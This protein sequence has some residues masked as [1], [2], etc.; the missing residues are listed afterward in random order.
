MVTPGKLLFDFG[1]GRASSAWEIINDGVMGGVSSSDFSLLPGFGAVFSGNVS[2]DNG[3]GF[4]S[5]R[6]PPV[7]QGLCGFV[8][9]V[10]RVRGDGRRFKFNVR[11]DSRPD[12]PVY[13]HA[14]ATTRGAWQE[15]RLG[16]AQ[17]IP[18]LRGRV[19]SNA[20][21]MNPARIAALGFLIAGQQSGPFRLE[22][23]WIK[24][25]GSANDC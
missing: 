10:L 12:S 7:D 24:A 2:L 22:I 1:A 14:F 8:S 17:F 4:A 25:S 15:H 18:S 9:F 23:A 5:V 19:L 13:Q 20:P 16:F 21:P 3:G 6:S 11:T